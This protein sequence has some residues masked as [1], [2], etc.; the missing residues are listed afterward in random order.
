MSGKDDHYNSIAYELLSLLSQNQLADFHTRIE[1]LDTEAINNNNIKQ[2]I[3]M[4]QYFI[5]GRY[6]KVLECVSLLQIPLVDSLLPTL[7]QT[8]VEA[9]ART[10]EAA[11]RDLPLDYAKRVLMVS[12]DEE[13][14]AVIASVC[15]IDD[16]ECRW[17]A[18]SYSAQLG[19]ERW[20]RSVQ[21]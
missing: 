19:S 18:Y 9:V 7:K 8:I 5:E 14:A 1:S 10:I 21:V 12:S 15:S 16:I 11:Y 2:V 6:E 13:L 3:C 17:S 4:E 20:S